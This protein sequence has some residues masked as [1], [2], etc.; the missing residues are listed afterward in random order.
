[1]Y[2]DIANRLAIAS[3]ET[4]YSEAVSM[5]GANAVL[6]CATFFSVTSTAGTVSITLQEGNDLDNW[7]DN[8]DVGGTIAGTV[9]SYGTM[10]LTALASQYVRLK[11]T[12]NGASQR[13]VLSA[14]VNTAQ[15]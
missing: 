14:G 3:G 6:V 5:A 8:T 12:M 15:L 10:K 2:Y 9:P 4:T 11:Y 13:A 1:M 7:T